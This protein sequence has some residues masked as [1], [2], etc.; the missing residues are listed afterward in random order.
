MALAGGRASF[1]QVAAGEGVV[2]A[3]DGTTVVRLE[4][5]TGE[6]ITRRF[7][8]PCCDSLYPDGAVVA[9]GGLWTIAGGMLSHRDAKTGRR[10][11]PSL[12]VGSAPSALVAD[13]GRNA[14]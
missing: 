13:V 3:A 10:E 5:V 14:Q 11:A 4:P 9:D 2:W 1:S 6:P 8:S 7:P 12:R